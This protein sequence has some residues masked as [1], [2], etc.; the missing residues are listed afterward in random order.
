[1]IPMR[2]AY[3]YSIRNGKKK[4]KSAEKA[5]KKAG[6]KAAAGQDGTTSCP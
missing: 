3:A 2:E 1:M 5:A 6:A 4:T